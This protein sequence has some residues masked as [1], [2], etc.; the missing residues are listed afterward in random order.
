MC[1][2]CDR[3]GPAQDR[4]NDRQGVLFLIIVI[5]NFLALDLFMVRKTNPIKKIKEF[6][7][8]YLPMTLGSFV[9]F[10]FILYFLYIV[11]KTT[12]VNYQSNKEI[13]REETEINLAEE[14][15]L[16]IRNQINYFQTKSY[17][18]K[19]AREKLG[20]KA[21]GESVLSMPYDIIK[22]E[23]VE[24]ENAGE[25]RI[26]TPNYRLWWSYFFD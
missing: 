26:K 25:I 20:Y 2:N 1:Y 9:I 17:R 18:E 22:G 5:A 24:E 14:D 8:I 13:S 21:P 23:N 6:I 3:Y 15:L 16:F 12:Y 19:E 4:K 7:E 11:G 10:I